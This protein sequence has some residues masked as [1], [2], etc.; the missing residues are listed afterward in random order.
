MSVRVFYHSL[1]GNTKKVAEKI[2]HT[3]GCTAEPVGAA[4]VSEPVNILFLGA[5]V[6]GGDVDALV[7]KFIER[8]DPAFIKQVTVFGTGFQEHK[9]QVVGI[10]KGLLAQR[11][12]AATDKCYFCRGK[13]LLFNRKSPDEQDLKGAEEF[14]RSVLTE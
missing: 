11:G 2:A 14:A 5:A 10:M 7:K 13:F 1:T 6:H 9:D 12:I 8:L 4:M 3:V